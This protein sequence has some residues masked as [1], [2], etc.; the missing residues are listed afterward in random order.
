M[1]H[2]SHYPGIKDQKDLFTTIYKPK[3]GY[4]HFCT[5]YDLEMNHTLSGSIMVSEIR[6]RV[7]GP[8]IDITTCSRFLGLYT[9]Y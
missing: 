2:I 6:N 7:N 4:C 3:N 5:H 8:V 9:I 1:E